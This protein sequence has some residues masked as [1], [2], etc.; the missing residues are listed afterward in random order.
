[1]MYHAIVSFRMMN[2]PPSPLCWPPL[3]SLVHWSSVRVSCLGK[4][5]KVKPIPVRKPNRIF[6][7]GTHGS[8][9][10]WFFWPIFVA[11]KSR[12]LWLLQWTKWILFFFFRKFRRRKWQRLVAYWFTWWWRC[13]RFRPDG[14][15]HRRLLR[16]R[17]EPSTPTAI[18]DCWTADWVDST[19]SASADWA[20]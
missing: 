7:A 4:H 17:L 15:L 2:T 16:R 3:S 1:M 11:P 18:R 12:D 20:D 14:A 6:V 19:R 10:G 8:L 9:T 13:L 5:F